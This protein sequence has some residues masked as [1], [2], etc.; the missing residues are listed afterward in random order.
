MTA[1]AQ[2]VLDARAATGRSVQV[3]K[4]F[5]HSSSRLQAFSADSRGKVTLSMFLLDSWSCFYPHAPLSSPSFL[6]FTNVLLPFFPLP[7]LSHHSHYFPPSFTLCNSVSLQDITTLHSATPFYMPPWCCSITSSHSDAKEGMRSMDGCP[8][9]Q[10]NTDPLRFAKPRSSSPLGDANRSESDFDRLRVSPRS[11]GLTL[12]GA[13]DAAETLPKS[14]MSALD[15]WFSLVELGSGTLSA[16]V[17]ELH[18]APPWSSVSCSIPK[19]PEV[20]RSF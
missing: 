20:I 1:Q 13:A 17:L 14:C 7:Q 15:F 12:S 8:D 3:I 19:V 10:L 16:I 11:A 6:L 18:V 4:P 9:L 5:M 2:L